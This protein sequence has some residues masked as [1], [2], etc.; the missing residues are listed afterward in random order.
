M[1]LKQLIQAE[2]EGKAAIAKAKKDARDLFAIEARSAEQETA[3]KAAL[4][5]IDQLEALRKY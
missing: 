5:A 2:I 3:L 1:K 4:K